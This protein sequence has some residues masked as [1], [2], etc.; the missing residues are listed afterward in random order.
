[1]G[2]FR[3]TVAWMRGL[4]RFRPTVA[5]MR[6]LGRFRQTV[7]WMT[8]FIGIQPGIIFVLSF[9]SSPAF[10][11]TSQ[12]LAP[13]S[14][15]NAGV[16]RRRISRWECYSVMMIVYSVLFTLFVRVFVETH[17]QLCALRMCRHANEKVGKEEPKHGIA[18]IPG[19]KG[20]V[21]RPC[22][23]LA[24]SFSFGYS[25]CAIVAL[26]LSRKLQFGCVSGSP[27]IIPFAVVGVIAIL[28]HGFL[29]WVAITQD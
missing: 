24:I 13:C 22:F 17:A 9:I 3:Q 5:W 6:G 10:S 15:C 27:E 23:C 19:W 18:C 2:K 11:G 16:L 29:G 21:M 20:K 4:G 1:M 12:A 7:A 14:S 25:I 28:V 8:C 26:Y